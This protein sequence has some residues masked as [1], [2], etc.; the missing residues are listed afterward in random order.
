MTEVHDYFTLPDTMMTCN[1][2]GDEFGLTSLTTDLLA[3][4]QARHPKEYEDVEK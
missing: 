1:L 3:H 2:C 4:M